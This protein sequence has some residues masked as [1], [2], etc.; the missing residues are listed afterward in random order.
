[1]WS[2]SNLIVWLFLQVYEKGGKMLPGKKGISLTIDQY[3][4]L[5]DLIV[6]GN[7]Q[8]AIQALH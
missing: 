5:K 8:D 4:V 6:G 3:E 2:E 1:V 7:I